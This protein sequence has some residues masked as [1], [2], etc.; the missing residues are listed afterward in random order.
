MAL[1]I[2]L[3]VAGMMLGLYWIFTLLRSDRVWY[4]IL[5]VDG[6][7]RPDAAAFDYAP[8][9]HVPKALEAPPALAP[10]RLRR[11]FGEHRDPLSLGASKICMA[12]F[13][14]MD[15]RTWQCTACHLL[16][17]IEVRKEDE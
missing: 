11:H 7:Y 10:P 12:E 6:S 2:L 16:Q 1:T 9:E 13:E 5:G 3:W 4:W 8:I 17:F 15:A 14:Q